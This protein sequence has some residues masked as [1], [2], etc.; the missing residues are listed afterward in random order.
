MIIC[1]RCGYQ[2]PDGSPWCPRCGFGCPYPVQYQQQPPQQMPVPY[3][4]QPIPA[5]YD[6]IDIPPQPDPW[7]TPK[8][9]KKKKKK[10]LHGCIIAILAF[11]G[12]IILGFVAIVIAA[13]VDPST[14]DITK[15]PTLSYDEM[16]DTAV[17]D[18]QQYRN[19]TSTAWALSVTPT[20]TVTFTP[21]PT[22]TPA[23]INTPV[24]TDTP[25]PT[26]TLVPVV[27]APQNQTYSNNTGIRGSVQDTSTNTCAVK[28]SNSGIYHCSN[29]PNYNTMKNYVCFSSQAEAEAAGYTMSGNM[30]GWC[31]Q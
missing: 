2:A 3:Q 19:E 24:P 4:P 1:P 20:F 14:S 22:N 29:S 27:A 21:E 23:P 13:I 15:T 5:Q 30:H 10:K 26:D 12:V 28:G 16:M 8:R 9:K 6:V 7:Q 11:L 18:A 31:A 17:A 25:I